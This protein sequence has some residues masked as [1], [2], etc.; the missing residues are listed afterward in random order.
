MKKYLIAFLILNFS[1]VKAQLYINTVAGTSAQGFSGDGG[2]ST[3]ASLNQAAATAF[4]AAG[5]MYIADRSNNRIRKVDVNGIITTIAG[6]GA[7]AYGG[8]GGLATSAQLSIPNAVALDG[9]GN[10]YICDN[11]NSRIRMINSS[12]IITTVAGTNA[13]GFSGDGGPA[14]SAQ[15]NSPRGIAFDNSGNLFI[16]DSYNYRIRKVS[17]GIISTVAGTGAS[18]YNG[19]GIAATSANLNVP[20]DVTFDVSGNMYI[21]DYYNFRIRKVNTTG[22]ISTICGLSSAGF[23]GDGGPATT[24]TIDGPQGLSFDAQGNL[25]FID[26]LNNRLRMIN[27]SG[28]INTICGTGTW[29]FSG[30][31]GPASSAMV[32][33]PSG[34]TVAPTG[35]I[36]LADQGNNRIRR[37]NPNLIVT[38]NTATIC[39]GNSATLTASG[40]NTYS[41]TP[42]TGLSAITGASVIA[43]PTI[44]T[45]YTVTGIKGDSIGTAIATV[46]V[47]NSVTSNTATVCAGNTA[48]LTAGGADTYTWNTGATGAT[49]TV[50]PA[51]S[52]SYTVTGSTA[53]CTL[54]AAY[55]A[56]VSVNP[57][58]VISVN[59][60]STAV[61]VGTPLSLVAGGASTYTWN[62][63]TVSS[64]LTVT[65]AV[66]TGYT[67]TGKDA[68]NCINTGNA[69]VNVNPLPSVSIT[70]TSDSI[71][72]GTSTTLTASG[73]ATYS[74]N[75]G[76][77]SAS[78]IYSPTL[79]TTYTVTGTD[80][81]GCKSKQTRKIVLNPQPYAYFTVNNYNPEI[82]DSIYTINNSI[83]QGGTYSWDFGPASTPQYSASQNVSSITYSTAINSYIK[84][85][86]VSAKGCRDSLIKALNSITPFPQDSFPYAQ[87]YTS[88]QN[89]RLNS[90]THDLNDNIYYLNE[91][92]DIAK[93]HNIYSNHGDS[94][95][96]YFT[97]GV[98]QVLSKLNKKGVPQWSTIICPARAT[99]PSTEMGA[100]TTDSIGNVYCSF[101]MGQHNTSDTIS[102]YSADGRYVRLMPPYIW[103]GLNASMIVTKYNKDGILQW[104]YSFP[105]LYTNEHTGLSVDKHGN[106]YSCT[107]NVFLKIKPNGTLHWTKS[108]S[109]TGADVSVDSKG[110]IWVANYMNLTVQKYDTSGNLLFTTPSYSALS[111]SSISSSIAT[112]H[113]GLDKNDNIYLSGNFR[114]KYKFGTDTITD[115]YSGGASH[116][117]I[118]VCKINPNGQPQWIRQL[119]SDQATRAAGFDVKNDKVGFEGFPEGDTVYLVK[120]GLISPFTQAGTYVY[121]T[122]TAGGNQK[123]LKMYENNLAWGFNWGC[124]LLSF[125]NLTSSVSM[126]FSF[127]SSFPYHGKTIVPKSLSSTSVGNYFI[128]IADVN[129]VTQQHLNAPVSSFSNNTVCEGSLMSFT[130]GSTN[131]PNSWIWSF[132]GG[133]PATSVSQNPSVSYS[134]AGTYT[135]SLTAGNS[136]GQ[137][138]TYT[139]LVTVNQLPGVS[140]NSPSTTVC[141]GT[142]LD[143]TAGGANTYTWSANAGSVSSGT[144][145]VNPH[146]NT[147]YSVA[148]A[149][150]NGCVNTATIS[151]NVLPAPSITT[152]AYA[153]TICF[154]STDTLYA[155]G[156]LNYLW[157]SNAGNVATDI[158]IVTPTVTTNYFVTGSAFNGCGTTDSILIT[159]IN[160]TTSSDQIKGHSFEF[161]PNPATDKIF[162]RS[163]S[164]PGMITIY[165]SLGEIVS[166]I[167]SKNEREQIDVSKFPAGIYFVEIKN[168]RIKLI[169]N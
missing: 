37:I 47:K 147:V 161:Y 117:D 137:G 158:A 46:T 86:V 82:G 101:F 6:T 56:N 166:C 17:G 85:V 120:S 104:Y 133:N 12:G 105:E 153:D 150:V 160:C 151:I 96:T 134:V 152:W 111:S 38:V 102:I 94:C 113:M 28:I 83:S 15:L 164:E 22:T 51:T 91:A 80:I 165:N 9:A 59:P 55:V 110:Y 92:N 128:G 48:T 138:N 5:N 65:P 30:D 118:F 25:Y 136:Y 116:E 39:S 157:D 44:T 135:V 108:M 45:T 156:A 141:D 31:G 64:V 76:S 19:D 33:A 34:V 81:N 169:K 60:T 168:D 125:G 145:A 146:V 84:M 140:I 124:N 41:W 159:V 99:S 73:A 29:G 63:G 32:H 143:L 23:G 79:T 127:A 115:I 90:L 98:G 114:G 70:A 24:A 13:A 107:D 163:I 131:G 122:D 40:G 21:A 78:V 57:L 148:G 149:D 119:K 36:Y 35:V 87:G 130:D 155:G 14:T 4:D 97:P 139:T 154:G 77:L 16:A 43:S 18:S 95:S 167:K 89:N 11:G 53:G 106:T 103:N 1:I 88:D 126:A 26:Y 62:T 10:L 67:V 66:T 129:S 112:V 121:L 42:S 52:T 142:V 74:W 27:T 132:P 71:C 49:L 69:L 93:R 144:V 72:K 54:T 2:Q 123:L 61:C 75:T 3:V 109:Q 20:V 100:L 50:S 7:N 8:D 68:N 58:P 162:V